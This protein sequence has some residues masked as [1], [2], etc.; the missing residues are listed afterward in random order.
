GTREVKGQK[1]RYG[2]A[3]NT[4]VSVVEFGAQVQARSVLIFGQ[5]GDPQSPHYFDQAPLYAAGKFKPAWFALPE[6]RANARRGYHPGETPR[7]AN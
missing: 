6:I 3:G 2:T 4:Y 5:S 1:R 7:E